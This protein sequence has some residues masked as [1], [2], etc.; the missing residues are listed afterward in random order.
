MALPL[1]RCR[2]SFTP[3][4]RMIPGLLRLWIQPA[5]TA[6]PGGNG[7]CGPFAVPAETLQ[8]SSRLLLE[9]DLNSC[10]PRD[11]FETPGCQVDLGT[12]ES[13]GLVGWF[14]LH[15]SRE[16][17]DVQLTTAPTAP[18]T[19]WVQCWMPFRRPLSKLV[20]QVRLRLVAQSAAA[21]LPEL[22]LVLGGEEVPEADL[23]RYFLDRGQV[24]FGA[25][26]DAAAPPQPP[27]KKQR[28]S[29]GGAPDIEGCF[30][31]SD[32]QELVSLAKEAVRGGES[33][34]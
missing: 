7:R 16:H 1:L 15:A 12:A 18:Q 34:H 10:G 25:S 17:E 20:V 32:V 19:H 5:A 22:C 24:E 29:E 13:A 8:G 14:D 31:P 26:V 2:D 21:G 30:F 6:P 27:Q 3:R 33:E 9:A 4:P 11:L 23:A 28:T